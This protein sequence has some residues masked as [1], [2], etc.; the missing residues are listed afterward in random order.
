MKLSCHCG[1]VS[2][3]A[4]EPEQVAI[5]NCSICRRYAAC[6]A[7][8]DPETVQIRVERRA[9]AFYQW[10]DRMVEFH[11]CPECGCVTHYRTNERC[12]R[13]VTAINMRLAEPEWLATV[14]VRHI[15]G[16]SY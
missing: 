5:C 8:Y 12:D 15:D 16:A 7:Y 3:Q 11:R 6:W 2:L 4:P 9:T 14:P 1:N 10:G 13:A